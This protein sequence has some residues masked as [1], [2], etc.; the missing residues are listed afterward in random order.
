MQNGQGRVMESEKDMRQ[1]CI[2]LLTEKQNFL[3]SHGAE[4][5]PR[6]ADFSTEEV[7]A[8]KAAL[9]PW[10][11]ALESAGLKPPRNG[12]RIQRNREKRARAKRR[13][14]ETQ[15]AQKEKNTASDPYGS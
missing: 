10:P 9:G 11:R 15:K 12:D 3:Q 7:V 2:R 6:R 5:L 14:R 1:K 4:R 8:I 13:R